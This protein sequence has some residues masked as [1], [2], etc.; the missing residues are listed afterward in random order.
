MDKVR[1]NSYFTNF[2]FSNNISTVAEVNLPLP[3]SEQV[4]Q[5]S[6]DLAFPQVIAWSAAASG[7][8]LVVMLIRS[9]TN[10]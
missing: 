6:F 2:Y 7:I 9:F 10:K 3:D 4:I 5:D 1:S 8:I